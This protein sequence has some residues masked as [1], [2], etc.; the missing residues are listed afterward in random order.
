FQYF[1]EQPTLAR[2]IALTNAADIPQ[3]DAL[4]AALAGTPVNDED[5]RLARQWAAFMNIRYAM[6]HRDKLPTE[7]EAAAVDLLGLNLVAEDGALALYEVPQ[8]KPPATYRIGE[9][10]GRMALGEG[11]APVSPGASGTAAEPLPAFAQRA[12]ARLLLPL[13]EAAQLRIT[14]SALAPG[15]TVRVIA[16]GDDLGEQPLPFATTELTFDVPARANRPPLSDVRLRF[17][18]IVPLEQLAMQLSRNGPGGLLVRSAG[19]EAGDFGHIFLD[20]RDISPNQRG[21]NLVALDDRGALLDAA[22]FDTHADPAA[23]SRMAAWIRSQPPGTVIAGAVRDEASM[24]LGQDAVDALRSLDL[25]VDLRGHFRWGHA[26]IASVGAKG[27]FWA[28]NQESADAIRPVQLSFG[29]PLSEP[30][31]VAAVEQVRIIK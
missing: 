14:A 15:Q 5:R 6:V 31:A 13:Q 11:W 19:Q 4:R 9:D 21:Y 27:G 23:S 8:S 29:F 22:N 24:N 20:G 12:E 30:R 17:G 26:F 10:P 1:S 28:P 16:D 7:T 2:L 18:K 3:H 25:S